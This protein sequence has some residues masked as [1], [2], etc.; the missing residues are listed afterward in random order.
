MENDINSLMKE[1][2][3]LKIMLEISNIKA[4]EREKNIE[5]LFRERILFKEATNKSVLKERE[6][7]TKI[8]TWQR[9]VDE[10]AHSI[11]T[12]VFIAVSNLS[13]FQNN[14]RIKKSF[15]HIKQIRDLTNLLMWYL[16]RDELSIS[17]EMCEIEMEKMLETQIFTIKDGISTLRLSN[18]EH[19]ER[20]FELKIPISTTGNCIITI[21][22]EISDAITLIVKDLLKNALKNTDEISPEVKISIKELKDSVRIDIINNKAIGRDY[23]DWFN[24]SSTIEPQNISKSFK[25][26]LRVIKMWNELL[27]LKAEL[28]PDEVN[29]ITVAKILIPKTIKYGK[30]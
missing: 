10:L 26:G 5:E 1:I 21:N 13:K 6:L 25:V 14:P 17:G 29:N 30:S 24:N 16:K 12:D 9:V 7:L 23:S 2:E 4:K 18:E 15:Y 28:I 3:K 11:N 8:E 20:L 27:N 19:Q 22:K